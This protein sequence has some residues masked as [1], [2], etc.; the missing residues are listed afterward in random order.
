MLSKEQ[1]DNFKTKPWDASPLAVSE[2]IAMLEAAQKDAARYRL[3]RRGQHWD[4]VDGYGDT[5]RAEGLDEAIDT[6]MHRDCD[7]AQHN[8]Q[9]TQN[10]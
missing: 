3:V 6:V 8:N 5:L 4:V 10:D 2:L 7:G 9:E 1:I